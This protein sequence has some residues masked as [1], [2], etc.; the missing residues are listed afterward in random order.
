MQRVLLYCPE[1][2][3]ERAFE[4][5]PCA[6]EHGDDCPERICVECGLAVFAGTL[7]AAAPAEP[8][9]YELVSRRVA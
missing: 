3:Q 5:P 4:T 7:P 9:R 1:C 6:D 8:G 2:G